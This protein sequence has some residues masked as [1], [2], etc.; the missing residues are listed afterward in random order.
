[1]LIVQVAGITILK[2]VNDGK[3]LCLGVKDGVIPS[4]FIRMSE[5]AGK[6]NQTGEP[7][8]DEETTCLH[9]LRHELSDGNYSRRSRRFVF[10]DFL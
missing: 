2:L 8:T 5:L 9:R 1:M 3:K 6:K 10:C 4:E 7:L